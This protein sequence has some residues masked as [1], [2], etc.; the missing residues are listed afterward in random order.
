MIGDFIGVGGMEVVEGVIGFCF[1]G[2]GGF[3]F[4]FN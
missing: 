3:W 1:G 2:G 4:V